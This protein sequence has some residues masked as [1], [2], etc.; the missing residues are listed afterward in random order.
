[1]KIYMI[2]R[3][4][5]EVFKLHRGKTGGGPM[6]PPLILERYMRSRIRANR[7]Q[8][9]KQSAATEPHRA[10]CRTTPTMGWRYQGWR[11]FMTPPSGWGIQQI[12][13]FLPPLLLK[14][15]MT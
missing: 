12:A 4:P 8:K 1:M 13:G 2:G 10:P 6:P 7:T 11:F 9:K 14:Y 3:N 15:I 5:G